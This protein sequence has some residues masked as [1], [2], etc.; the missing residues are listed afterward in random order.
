MCYLLQEQR[1]VSHWLLTASLTQLWTQIY[2]CDLDTG[3]KS[4]YHHGVD[5]LLRKEGQ[6]QNR[7]DTVV[8]ALEET[9]PNAFMI[10]QTIHKV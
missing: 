6:L 8:S 2:Q 9:G 3:K 5:V 7:E 10:S 4:C 1:S